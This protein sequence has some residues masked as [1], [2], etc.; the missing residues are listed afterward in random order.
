M[1]E[2]INPHGMICIIQHPYV[3]FTCNLLLLFKTRNR[4]VQSGNGFR[5]IGS[6]EGSDD[7]VPPSLLLLLGLIPR[8]NDAPHPPCCPIAVLL[9]DTLNLRV[10]SF[11]CLLGQILVI[12]R[13]SRTMSVVVCLLVLASNW[14]EFVG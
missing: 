2:G 10:V 14:N 3:R 4:L 8:I 6:N 5:V 13:L 7:V 9:S 12:L 11:L 1:S